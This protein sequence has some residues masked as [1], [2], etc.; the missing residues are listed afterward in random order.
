MEG[1]K[2]IKNELMLPYSVS[3][4]NIVDPIVNEK[5][6]S[7][8]VKEIS[9]AWKYTTVI[10]NKGLIWVRKDKLHS[11][12]RTRKNNI[13]YILMEILDKDKATFG[14]ELYIRGCKILE[15]IAINIEENGVGTKG[16]YLEVSR[17][18]YDAIL[19]CDKAKVLR[20]EVDNELKSKRKKLKQMR[21]KKYNIKYDE[22]TKE[23]LKNGSDFSH[24][25][26][27]A[28]YKY[29]S[30]NIENGLIINKETHA[31]ITARGIND[32]EELLDLCKEMNW[33]ISWYDNFTYNIIKLLN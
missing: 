12:L 17:M 6:K 3:N 15:I 4:L 16:L 26:S 29:I 9:N 7:K 33:D 25:R 20:L 19:L 22:L 1:V 11:I 31:I 30:D 5:A 10:D 27:V 14:G 2:Y 23:P 28:M 13:E 32:E 18:F 8:V 24:I 21:I